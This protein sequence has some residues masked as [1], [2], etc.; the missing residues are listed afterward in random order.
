MI[1]LLLSELLQTINES[2][3]IDV[4]YIYNN[5]MFTIY[6]GRKNQYTDKADRTIKEIS[7]VCFV[8]GKNIKPV[9]NIQVNN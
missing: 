4:F 5:I 8:E 9:I 2:T 7:A 1:A 3:Y 6:R